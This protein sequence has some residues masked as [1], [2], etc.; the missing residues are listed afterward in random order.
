LLIALGLVLLGLLGYCW[1][2]DDSLATLVESSGQLERDSA[3]RRERWLTAAVGDRFGRGDGARTGAQASAYFRLINGAR[4]RLQPSSQVRFQAP[5]GQSSLKLQVDLGQ[6]DVQSAAGALQVDSEFGEL[7]LDANSSIRLRRAAD[8]LL[9]EVEVGRLQIGDQPRAVGAGQA[10][11]LEIGGIRLDPSRAEPAAPAADAGAA[12]AARAPDPPRGPDAGL[13]APGLHP[14]LVV[15]AGDSFVVH[16]PAPSLAI[17]F[18][19]AG[20]CAGPARLVSGSQSTEAAGLLSLPFAA[21]RHRYEL[22]CLDRPRELAAKGSFTVVPDAGTRQLPSFA[23]TANVIT[24]GRSYT[25]MYQF[26]LPDVT[27]SWSAAPPAESYT[28]E[29]D[30]RTLQT[31]SPSRELDALSSGTHWVAFSAATTPARRS[32]KTSIDVV[33][34]RQAPAAR[35]SAPAIGFAAA[36]SVAVTGQ[37]LPGW[38]VSIAG[39]PIALDANRNFSTQWPGQGVIPIAFSHPVHGTHYYLR[40]PR[41]ASP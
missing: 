32:R 14:D 17:G 18:E 35:V 10:I 26:R 12:S 38:S 22:R 40:R 25:V 23:P 6:V 36:A 2:R 24:D 37:A 21:G 29:I 5:G 41:G 11:A 27:V 8:R 1:S 34:D 30:G 7:H 4:L 16:D 3:S 20:S 31:K 28:L 13:P 33:L 15:R 9:V 39:E 19:L